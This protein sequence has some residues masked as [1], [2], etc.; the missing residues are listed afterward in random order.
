MPSEAAGSSGS[1]LIK[2]GRY[3]ALVFRFVHSDALPDNLPVTDVGA[4]FMPLLAAI[5]LVW[6]EGGI[7]PV[8][9]LL[10]RAA[11]FQRIRTWRWLA[12]IV[13]LMPCVYA[14]T[15]I[16]M[17]AVGMTL[18]EWRLPAL[19]LGMAF[20]AFFIA[21]L[22]EEL[23]YTGYVAGGLLTHVPVVQAGVLIGVPW[24]LWHL[25]SMIQLGQPVGLIL[26]GDG[27]TIAFRV[28]YVWVFRT[29]DSVFAVILLHTIANTGRTFF[30]GGR[31]AFEQHD[32]IIG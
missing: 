17:Q 11:D 6:R 21:A 30:P 24:A 26:M 20:L 25:P 7:S 5:I 8:K 29:T 23:A 31:A 4:V 22:A 2:L 15:S 10:A 19:G 14:L 16:L 13:G 28:I 12:L 9:V 27:A 18:P 32:A 1:S 3:F